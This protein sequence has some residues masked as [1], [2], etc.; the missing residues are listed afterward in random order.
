MCTNILL[1]FVF[2]HRVTLYWITTIAVT[3]FRINIGAWT[4]RTRG[5]RCSCKKFNFRNFLCE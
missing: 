1:L 2:P 3:L 5:K 4:N